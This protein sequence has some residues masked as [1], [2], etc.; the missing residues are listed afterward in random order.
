MVTEVHSGQHRALTKRHFPGAGLVSKETKGAVTIDAN[1][2]QSFEQ[3]LSSGIKR[4]VSVP[5][6]VDWT[7]LCGLVELV[8]Y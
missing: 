1:P 4:G 8:L 2:I 3:F 5:I 6:F 7:V